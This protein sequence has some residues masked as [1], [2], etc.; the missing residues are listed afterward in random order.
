MVSVARRLGYVEDMKET[1]R[2]EFVVMGHTA[3]D[4]STLAARQGADVMLIS[5]Q[6]IE[7]MN[8]AKHEIE[9][10]QRE[11]VKIR[12]N[13]LPVKVLLDERTGRAKALRVIEVEWVKRQ[14][15]GE[16]GHRDGSR[17]R[18]HRLRHR[19]DRRP[20]AA[21]RSSTTARA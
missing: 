19:P 21:W 14:A 1:E 8:A 20:R 12:G 17:G 11:G 9:D 5:M 16:A 18:S 7:E 2:P 13:L 6:P 10:A 15:G 3:H 4:V